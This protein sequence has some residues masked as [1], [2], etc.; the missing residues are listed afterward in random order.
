MAREMNPV[1]FTV[2]LNGELNRSVRYLC[3]VFVLAGCDLPYSDI[4]AGGD[5]IGH[6]GGDNSVDV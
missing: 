5:S 6:G 4:I 1:L 2:T 3:V